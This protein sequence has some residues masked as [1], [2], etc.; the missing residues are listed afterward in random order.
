MDPAFLPEFKY[1][2]G[3]SR[4][5]LHDYLMKLPNIESYLEKTEDVILYKCNYAGEKPVKEFFVKDSVKET[6]KER[7]SDTSTPWLLIPIVI[8]N[9]FKCSEKRNNSKHVIY[10]L[11]H[12]LT[13]TVDRIDIKKFHIQRFYLK[14]CLKKILSTFVPQYLGESVKFNGE[15]DIDGHFIK[16]FQDKVS[17]NVYP[18]Y[19]INLLNM[20]CQ[21]PKLTSLQIHKK[22][23]KLKKEVL[24]KTWDSYAHFSLDYKMPKSKCDRKDE[25]VNLENG[26]CLLRTSKNILKYETFKPIPKCPTDKVYN[27]YTNRCTDPSKLKEI[28]ILFNEAIGSRASQNSNI[29]HL[30]NEADIVNSFKFVIS[31]HQGLGYFVRPNSKST[32]ANKNMIIWRWNSQ[33]DKMALTIPE[34]FWKDWERGLQNET[35][36]FMFVAIRLKEV[37]GGSHANLFVYDKSTGEMERFDGLGTRIHDHYEIETFDKLMKEFFEKQRGK[38]IPNN[39]KYLIPIDYC[40]REVF[41]IKE[42]DEISSNDLRGNCA[43]WRLWY[44][45]LRL[46]NPTLNRKQ[47]VRMAMKKL[48]NFGSFTRFIKSYQKYV[49]DHM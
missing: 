20:R 24:E 46:S 45:D 47:L 31:K 25:I 44:I 28:D 21:Y 42:L 39:F 41:Q 32:S 43:V 27:I 5:V 11:Y 30:G 14:V 15:I 49:T 38:L 16:V 18:I 23:Y 29:R 40:P 19:L 4:L 7:I 10:L 34:T 9:K 1:T 3:E 37:N 26:K 33:T 12:K 13:N 48:Q 36:R 8:V 35:A 2:F 6:L 22:L 17:K